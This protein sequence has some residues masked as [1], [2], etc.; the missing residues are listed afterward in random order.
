[1]FDDIVDVPVDPR[2]LRQEV[3]GGVQSV[4][5]AFTGLTIV[6]AVLSLTNAISQSVA[7]R[8]GEFGLRRA[9]GAR[10]RDLS[11][12]VTIEAATVGVVGGVTGLF[13][14]TTAILVISITQRWVP[15]LDPVLVPVALV[16]GVLLA[17]AGSFAGA[18]RAARI[19]PHEALRG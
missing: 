8:S 18:R 13:V 6:V 19:H 4:L 1:M 2:G 10:A 14:G 12:L 11:A 3:E 7:G 17:I 5:A 15:V 9:I 16:G